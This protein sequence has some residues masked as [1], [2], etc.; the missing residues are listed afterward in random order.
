MSTPATARQSHALP[1]ICHAEQ[2]AKGRIADEGQK[3][4]NRPETGKANRVAH[5]CGWIVSEGRVREVSR[6]L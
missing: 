6:Q 1:P 4:A 2:A 5:A 3:P